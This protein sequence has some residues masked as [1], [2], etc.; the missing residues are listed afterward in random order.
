M[1][2]RSAVLVGASA[3]SAVAF[4]ADDG[5]KPRD[6]SFWFAS[7]GPGFG[8]PILGSED[9]RRGGFYSVGYATPW[10][11]ITFRKCEG[12]IVMQGYYMFTNG[13][14]F[15]DIPVNKMDTT[16]LL[17]TGRYHNHWFKGMDTF[18]EIGWGFSYSS[19]TTRDLDSHWNST[20][21]IGVGASW[22]NGRDLVFALVRWFHMSN[23]GTDGNN[24][25]FNQFQYIVGI[26]F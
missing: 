20:P 1:S 19:L 10:N 7:A 26:K 25:G 12:Q 8:Q 18:Y 5:R 14:G 23:A 22:S 9:I 2:W 11:G 15:E 6:E 3:L 4:G 21:T 24:Q 13:G 16:G 17:V